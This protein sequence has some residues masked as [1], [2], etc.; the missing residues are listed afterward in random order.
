MPGWRCFIIQPTPFC[1]RSLRRYSDAKCPT[2]SIHDM[3]V[4]IDE[5]VEGLEEGGLLKGDFSGDPRWPIQCACG[6]AFQEVDHWQVRVDRLY[7]GSPDGKDYALRDPDLP[8]GA[9]WDADWLKD[10]WKGP[11][12][13][14]LVVRLPGGSD[15]PMD[16]KMSGHSWSRTGI[17]PAVSVHPSVN[18]VGVYH[19]VIA[20][21]VVSEDCE[22]RAFP[23]IPRTA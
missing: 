5:K 17:P 9:T 13:L 20:N 10:P 19:G 21:G 18:H 22:G 6:Y 2:G 14:S 7:A 1:R 4:V 12:G 3:S 8:I 11:D 23:N 15:F 16:M